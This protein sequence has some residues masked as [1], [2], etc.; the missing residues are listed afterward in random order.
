MGAPSITIYRSIPEAR[1]FLR[2]LAAHMAPWTFD[3]ETYDGKVFPSRKNVSTSPTHPDFR[4][5]GCACAVS[6]DRGYWIEF[7]PIE[8]VSPEDRALLDLV[9]GSDAEKGAF[10]GGF[11]ENG[12][13]VPGWAKAVRNRTRDA[14]LGMVA[15]GDGTQEN[16]KLEN[17]IKVLLGLKYHWGGADK[18]LMRDIPLEEVAEG[19]VRDACMTHALCD[20]VDEWARRGDHILWRRCGQRMKLWELTK[21]GLEDEEWTAP[22]PEPP[23]EIIVS[24]VGLMSEVVLPDTEEDLYVQ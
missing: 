22:D 23:S 4:V 7:G 12:I 13:V 5:R 6:R 10:N 16:F 11:D 3:I 8:A 21:T 15:L 1:G 20:L 18:S 9:F 17:G 14:M 19:A 24:E 2:K